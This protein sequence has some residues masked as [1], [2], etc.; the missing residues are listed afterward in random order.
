MKYHGGLCL[1]LVWVMLCADGRAAFAAGATRP[2]GTVYNGNPSNYRTLLSGLAAGDTLQLAA[3]TYTQGLPLSN[4]NGAA[5]NPIIIT[6]PASGARAVFQADACICVNTVSIRDASYIEIRNLELDGMGLAGVDA[7]KAESTASFAHH[8]TLENL[9]IHGHDADQQ[10]VGI[11]TKTPTWDWVIRRNIIASAGTGMYLGDSNGGAPFVNGLIEGN[12]ITDTIGYNLQIKHQIGRP[13]LAGMPTNGI[14]II[15]HNVFSKAN[16]ASTGGNARP[17]VLVGHWP[18]TGSGASDIYLIYGNFFYQNPTEAL[19]QGE[20]NIALYDNLFVNRNGSAVN[21]QPHNDLPRTIRV[22]NNT[23][24]ATGIGIRVTGGDSGY[25]QKV[26]GNASFAATPINATDQSDNVTDSYANASNYLVNPMG[27]LGVLD[28]YPQTGM[29]TGSALDTSSFN[30]Y[31]DWNRDFNY[32]VHNGL[33]RGAYAGSGQNT[34]WLPKLERKP[35]PTN[36][37][38]IGGFITENSSGLSSVAF[39][40]S[41]ASC[42]ASDSGGVYTCTVS[43]GWSGTLTPFRLG[44]LFAPPSRAYTNVVTDTLGQNYTAAYVLTNFL[45]LPLVM[46]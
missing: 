41:G 23:V 16:N 24:V 39:T 5:G 44:Y 30:T 3:G 45:Y 8:I 36:T 35:L 15:R 6:G 2:P 26:I 40:S 20:G 31:Q 22:F 17:N 46:R 34:G 43:A 38:V 33:F 4:L 37:L 7:V 10:T 28:L 27:S 11:S 9:Y 25:Q 19:F 21:I 18:L 29:L 32:E 13:N 42:G 14:T 1:L 12:L